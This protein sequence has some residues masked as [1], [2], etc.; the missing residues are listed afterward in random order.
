MSNLKKKKHQGLKKHAKNMLENHYKRGI[1]RLEQQDILRQPA[2]AV[3][4]TS[5]VL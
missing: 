3:T 4:S 5:T 1:A 2:S